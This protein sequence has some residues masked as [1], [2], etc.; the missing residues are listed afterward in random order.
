M[1][2]SNVVIIAYD[3]FLVC[4]WIMTQVVCCEMFCKP[5]FIFY[6]STCLAC[7]LKTNDYC[8]I[9]HQLK[10]QLSERYPEARRASLKTGGD[11]PF[12]SRPDEV[13]LHLQVYMQVSH[14]SY[15]GY[16]VLM[17]LC[18]NLCLLS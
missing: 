3:Y 14:C 12:L 7:F 13:N 9:P 11:F 10:E 15:L 8:A 2:M 16:V 1:K 6:K 18:F 5:S 4:H 17:D